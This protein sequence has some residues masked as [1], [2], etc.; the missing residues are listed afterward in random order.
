MA[1]KKTTR[2]ARTRKVKTPPKTLK[3][4]IPVHVVLNDEPRKGFVAKARGL[5]WDEL[6]ATIGKHDA[7]AAEDF[8]RSWAFPANAAESIVWVEAT[9]P[10][11]T[12]TAPVVV[13]GEAVK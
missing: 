10:V 1:K 6:E 4:L 13:K 9:L 8:L 3:V 11:P 5:D 12:P 7:A 2:K